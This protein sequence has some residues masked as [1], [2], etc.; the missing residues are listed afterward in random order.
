[1]NEDSGFYSSYVSNERSFATACSTTS[2]TAG[3]N[4]ST[5]KRKRKNT[6]HTFNVYYIGRPETKQFFR[7][8]SLDVA[9]QT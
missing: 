4:T 3:S 7:L 6:K 2:Y 8:A 9:Q 1:M 5:L